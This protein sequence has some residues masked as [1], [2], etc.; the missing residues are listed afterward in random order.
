MR[1][2]RLPVTRP[3][4]LGD[5]FISPEGKILWVVEL[6]E[7]IRCLRLERGTW[8]I[9]GVTKVKEEKLRYYDRILAM[10]KIVEHK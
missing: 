3:V 1:N 8:T 4:I 10:L 2:N 9:L 7:P 5:T 6:S